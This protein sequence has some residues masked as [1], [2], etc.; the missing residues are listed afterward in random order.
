MSCP[1]S[2]HPHI[3][4]VRRVVRSIKFDPPARL[5]LHL[6]EEEITFTRRKSQGASL[7]VHG[8]ILEGCL[9]CSTCYKTL[10]IHRPYDSY[11]I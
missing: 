7:Q 3:L 10:L 1:S 11:S 8:T 9:A 4:S 2:T 5:G 6:H